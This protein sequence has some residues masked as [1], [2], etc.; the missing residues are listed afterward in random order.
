ME[1][2]LN[3][4]GLG[5]IAALQKYWM[6]SVQDYALRLEREDKV[7]IQE[8][9]KIAVSYFLGWSRSRVFLVGCYV[10]RATQGQALLVLNIWFMD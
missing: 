2:S 6:K 3:E 8:Y 7:M 4:I 9:H 1:Y 10:A 5:G